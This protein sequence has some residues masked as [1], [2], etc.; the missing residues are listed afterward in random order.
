VQALL[1]GACVVTV[2]RVAWRERIGVY[3][4]VVR[5]SEHHAD[6][7]DAGTALAKV[8]RLRWQDAHEVM[9]YA[10]EVQG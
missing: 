4:G 2:Y 1:A 8:E 5:Y 3:V 9:V 10:M 6:F 7:D